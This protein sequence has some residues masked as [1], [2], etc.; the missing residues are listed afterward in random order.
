MPVAEVNA[1][2][3]FSKSERRLLGSQFQMTTVDDERIWLASINSDAEKMHMQ[4]IKNS[5][6][7]PPSFML[8]CMNENISTI[9]K[10]ILRKK[11]RTYEDEF[12]QSN[13]KISRNAT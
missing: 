12:I 4:L 7:D 9:I 1:Q 10:I 3:F 6:T 11:T 2:S 5:S 8:Q 13:A